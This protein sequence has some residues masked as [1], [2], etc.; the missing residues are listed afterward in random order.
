MLHPIRRIR[1][2]GTVVLIAAIDMLAREAT[3]FAA[4][5]FLIGG[6]DDL[7]VDLIYAAWLIRLRV[8][9]LLGFHRATPTP[10]GPVPPG[11]IV[12]F[13]AA[14]EESGVI[15][16]ML[17]TALARFEHADYAIYV[18][19]YPNDPATIRA[20][21][22]VAEGDPRVRLVIGSAPGPTTK[23][24]CL[25]A[26]WR[27][28]LRD[29]AEEGFR[30]SAV[31]LHDAEDIVHPLELKI[32]AQW[33]QR[34]ATV[35]LPVLP[36]PHPRSRFIAGHYCDEFAE[37]HA[38]Q[39]VVRQALGA[40]LPLA[41]VG[42]AIRRD[43]LARIAEARGG[44]PF[45]ATSLTE[46]YELGLTISAMGGATALA[47]VPERPGGRPVAVRAYFPDTLGAA[48]RQKARWMTGIALAGW[49]RTGWRA[50][51]HLGDHW[52]RM[53][54]RRATLAMPVLAVAYCALLFWG[55]SLGGHL[56]AGSHAP[57]LGP[58]MRA[59]LWANFALLGWRLAVRAAF[60]RRAYGWCEACFSAPRVL[61]G[62]YIALL[63]A[64]RAVGI[65]ARLLLGGAP[66]W[67]KTDHQF[68]DAPEHVTA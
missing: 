2:A 14:W 18:G 52:M 11:R 12:V 19:T 55:A 68:P 1:G 20:V 37:A 47:R 48:V 3:L 67:D 15:G 28:L 43:M 38:K 63:A 56:L 23:A 57:S 62:N 40:G 61:V 66:K 51:A 9:R 58:A 41:G 27:A 44:A 24:D 36:L 4:I 49:D 30:A 46:D 35:Q 32:Y 7:L 25:N 33:L 42:C 65:Y 5:W 17:R 16:R 64:R 21:A 54:D 6:L 10:D 22:A 13:V 26:V 50:S 31:V 8:S 34:Y 29:E 45:D 39:L 60:V 53:R 59:L